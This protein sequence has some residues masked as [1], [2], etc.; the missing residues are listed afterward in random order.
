MFV[1]TGTCIDKEKTASRIC[2]HFIA[3]VYGCVLVY[4]C[5]DKTRKKSRKYEEVME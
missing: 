3:L 4:G 5:T 2:S 1:Q